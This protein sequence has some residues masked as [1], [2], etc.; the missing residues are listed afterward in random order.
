MAEKQ[1]FRTIGEDGLEK[2]HSGLTTLEEV[3]R[4][5][6]VEEEMPAFCPKCRE[7]V[8]LDF[9]ACPHC[10]Y[11]I[12][13]S[14]SFCKKHLQAEWLICPYCRTESDSQLKSAG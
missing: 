6:D 10:K 9:V 8:H 13:R 11:D 14:C 2:V 1:G 7:V 5:I 3:H 4:V 12:Q